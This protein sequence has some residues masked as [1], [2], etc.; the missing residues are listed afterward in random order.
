M[1][2][3]QNGAGQCA[4]IGVEVIEIWEGVNGCWYAQA[5]GTNGK[6]LVTYTALPDELAAKTAMRKWLDWW[7]WDGQCIQGH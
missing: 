3:Q 1:A 4:I 2:W 5:T 6:T 7:A